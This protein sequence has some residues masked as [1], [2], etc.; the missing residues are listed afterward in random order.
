MSGLEGGWFAAG[1]LSR[2]VEAFNCIAVGVAGG[3]VLKESE[4]P[5]ASGGGAGGEFEGGFV[6]GVAEDG[7][8][9][10]EP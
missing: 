2:D 9:G 6:L 5:A 10:E 1:T 7:G 3:K 4:P 8:G